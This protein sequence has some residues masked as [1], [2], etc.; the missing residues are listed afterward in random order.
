MR[1]APPPPRTG[2][3][4]ALAV[5]LAMAVP[6]CARQGSPPG[7]PVDRR[8]PLV[9]TTV[10]DTF[11]QVE[12][13]PDPLRIRFNERISARPASGTLDDAVL[14][15][16]RTGEVRVSHSRDALEV[17]LS[18]G[19]QPGLVYRVTVLPVIQ[20][21]FGN[22]MPEPFEFVFSTGAPFTPNVVAGM[23]MERTTGEPA[24]GYQVVLRRNEAAADTT[25]AHVG[26]TD[27]EGFFALRYLP[28]GRYELTAFQDI[29]R[30]RE[31]DFSEAR[32][33]MALLFR[34]ADTLIVEVPVL[35]SDTTRAVLGRAV[36]A[37]PTAIRLEFDDF[38][39]PDIPPSNAA[40][41]LEAD[42]MAPPDAPPAPAVERVLHAARWD[43]YR[44]S[45][46]AAAGPQDPDAAEGPEAPL[47][48]S[49]SRIPRPG[50]VPTTPGQ[51]RGRVMGEPLPSQS[52]YV[53]LEEPLPANIPYRLTVTGVV[54]INGFPFGGGTAVVVRQPEP[55]D[56]AAPLP[57]TAGV[58]P[59][60][61]GVAPDTALVPLDTAGVAP[62][63]ALV[64]PDTTAVPPDTARA[65]ALLPA[66]RRPRR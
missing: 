25:V 42:T 6:A 50:E 4:A 19:F 18:G 8:P 12:A 28:T 52:L 24:Q 53:L 45:V 21:M 43:A 7:G 22:T 10:P 15:S 13:V 31:I 33:S 1:A 3:G 20:D 38:L 26:V 29:N 35:R 36:P 44:D 49:V 65:G 62:D 60:T 66:A 27:D 47:P 56:T 37:T 40:V 39:D 30:N 34:D 32:G 9:I 46:R 59:D 14:V 5:L 48:P 16:P 11:A 57:D 17:D 55:V 58:A 41:A 51:G 2:W 23:V 64:A 61:V 54:N 63:T